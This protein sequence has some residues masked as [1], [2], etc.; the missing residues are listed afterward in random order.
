M[1]HGLLGRQASG[2]I[3]K[4][5]TVAWGERGAGS[6]VNNESRLGEEMRQKEGKRVLTEPERRAA[7]KEHKRLSWTKNRRAKEKSPLFGKTA[8]RV[9]T[10]TVILGSK[11]LPSARPLFTPRR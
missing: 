3:I 1:A 2:C 5:L 4:V 9:G 6:V 10:D 11:R 7:M 8:W